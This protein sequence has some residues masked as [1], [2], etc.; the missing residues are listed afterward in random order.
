M[1]W[2][3]I[4][5][6]VIKYGPAIFSIVSEIMDL[7]KKMRGAEKVEAEGEF[8]SAMAEYKKTRDR[9]PL[10]RLRERLQK[11]CYGCDA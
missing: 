6:W 5:L 2:L 11:R 4:I 8:K 1:A 10:R 7:I 3:S 9:R